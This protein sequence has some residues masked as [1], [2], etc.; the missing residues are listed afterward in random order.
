MNKM[1]NVVSW[2]IESNTLCESMFLYYDLEKDDYL[3]RVD[4]KEIYLKEFINEFK[5]G[6]KNLW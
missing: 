3:I 2:L 6:Q 4:G 5:N 1:K